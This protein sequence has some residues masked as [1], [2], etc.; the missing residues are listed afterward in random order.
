M[1]SGPDGG[2]VPHPET[3]ELLFADLAPSVAA[4]TFAAFAPMRALAEAAAR[5]D[6]DA[7]RAALAQL[8]AEPDVETRMRLQAWACARA[9]GVA[10]PDATAHRALGVVIDMGL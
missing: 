3:R 5:G 6:T 1:P 9:A 7:T 10:P 4:T 2:R 8:L